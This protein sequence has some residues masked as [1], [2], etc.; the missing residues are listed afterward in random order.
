MVSRSKNNQPVKSKK[1][2]EKISCERKRENLKKK[3]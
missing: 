2:S 1:V 3:N